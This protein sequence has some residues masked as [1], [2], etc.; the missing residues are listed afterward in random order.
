MNKENPPFFSLILPIYNVEKYLNRCVDSILKQKFSDYEI[1]LVDDESPD[2]CG[3]MCDEY[4]KKYKNIKVI[5]KKNEGLG[6]A[7]NSGLNIASGKYVWFIDSDDFISENSLY[8]LQKNIIDN[9]YPEIVCFGINY[10]DKKG[11]ILFNQCPNLDKMIYLENKNIIDNLLADFIY[12]ENNKNL[13]KSA[14]SKVYKKNF[15]KNNSLFFHSEREWISEDFYF[16]MDLFKY[17]NSISFINK[18]LY[19][20]CRNGNSLTKVYREDRFEKILKFYKKMDVIV[21]DYN[22]PKECKKRFR[23]TFISSLMACLKMEANNM[24]NIGFKKSYSRFKNICQNKF[25]KES[26]FLYKPNSK[27]WILF[28]KYIKNNNYFKLFILLFIK[29][30][31]ENTTAHK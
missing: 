19:N 11:K 29:Y 25:V 15:L 14:C 26:V 9:K 21:D 18:P 6:F 30:Q 24:K 4:A 28:E 13:H 16:C 27:N 8:N 10:I 1:I 3:T 31:M 17:I 5:H 12:D 7:R 2:N 20:Y 23:G 22:F